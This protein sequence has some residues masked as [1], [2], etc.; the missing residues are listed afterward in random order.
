[1]RRQPQFLGRVPVAVQTELARIRIQKRGMTSRMRIVAVRTFAG[2]EGAVHMSR[3]PLRFDF[4]VALEADRGFID[5]HGRFGRGS[6]REQQGDQEH[7]HREPPS[8]FASG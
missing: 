6:A 8:G 4:I 7:S 5:S 2:L 3:L 1:M